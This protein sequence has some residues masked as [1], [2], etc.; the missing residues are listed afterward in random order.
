M[1]VGKR[2]REIRQSQNKTLKEV[3]DKANIS[4]SYLSDIE[5]EKKNPSI[6]SI[7][8]ILNALNI[9]MFNFFKEIDNVKIDNFEHIGKAI[10]FYRNE[11]HLSIAELSKL[12]GIQ[13]QRLL[14]IESGKVDINDNEIKS[15][16]NI[17]NIDKDALFASASITIPKEVL[18]NSYTDS[19]KYP[20]ITDVKEAMKVILAQPGL[21]LNGEALSDESK[22]AL[23]NAINMGLAYAEQKQREEETKKK[24]KK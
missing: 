14:L 8:S 23:A 10:K 5:H 17:L 3:A 19:P 4:I 6:N 24:D 1:K 15:L 2:I 9:S 16:C 22:I 12:S 20:P 21:M 7:K 13:S 18:N 11:K